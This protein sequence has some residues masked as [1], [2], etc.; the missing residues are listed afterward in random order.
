MNHAE[1]PLCINSHVTFFSDTDNTYNYK[2][3]LLEAVVG[4]CSGTLY[5]YFSKSLAFPSWSLI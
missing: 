1:S 3:T 5:L 2:M 4:L